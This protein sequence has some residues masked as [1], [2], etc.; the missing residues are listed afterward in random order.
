MKFFDQVMVTLSQ[1][2]RVD[3]MRIVKEEHGYRLVL[4]ERNK[5][6]IPNS[7]SS[8][9]EFL[10]RVLGDL[11]GLDAILELVSK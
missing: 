6:H 4:K 8:T 10:F 9:L 5:F 1:M 11:K 7:V 3:V 2:N